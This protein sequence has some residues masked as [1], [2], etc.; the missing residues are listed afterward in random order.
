VR[1]HDG[2]GSYKFEITNATIGS[3]YSQTHSYS[4]QTSMGSPNGRYLSGYYSFWAYIDAGYTATD[5]NM[6]LGWMTG[7]SGKPSPISHVGLEVWKGK[8]QVVYLLKNCS[9]GLYPCPNIAGYE[10]AGG[11]Y[12]M[13]SSS[14][15]GIVE[16]PRNKWVHLSFYYKMSETNGRVTVWQDG[17]KIMDLT[18]PTMN[19]FGGHSWE[20]MTNRA[21]DMVL[22]F[23]QYGGAKN[24]GV[25]RM[26]VDDFMVTDYLITP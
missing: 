24:D 11:H 9:V 20:V 17:V 10:N 3:H 22:Q 21:G 19:T 15:A 2:N 7:V 26:Y 25:Q 16:F 8:L 6:L 5:W 4:P 14:P 23:G 12:A 13:T 1:S 18:A